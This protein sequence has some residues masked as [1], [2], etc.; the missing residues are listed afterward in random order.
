MQLYEKNFGILHLLARAKCHF[1]VDFDK[2]IKEL[3]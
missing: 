3:A 2:L 1:V